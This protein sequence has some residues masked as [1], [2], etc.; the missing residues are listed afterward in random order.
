MSRQRLRYGMIE[1]TTMLCKNCH[2]TGLT[3][4]NENL[5]LSILRNLEIIELEKNTKEINV[6]VPVDV[7][8]YILNYKRRYLKEIEKTLNTNIFIISDLTINNP[9]YLI[10]FR[11]NSYNN[12]EDI[13]LSNVITMDGSNINNTD[14]DLSKSSTQNNNTNNTEI[15]KDTK[16]KNPKRRRRKNSKFR[17]FDV[18]ND[19]KD[20]NHNFEDSNEIQKNKILEDLEKLEIKKVIDIKKKNIDSNNKILNNKNE[21]NNTNVSQNTKNVKHGKYQSKL[22]KKNSQSQDEL[23]HNEQHF[24][25]PANDESEKK[26][27]KTV[28][29]RVI[30]KVEEVLDKKNKIEQKK[31]T[32]G[33]NKK[34][35]TDSDIPKSGWWVRKN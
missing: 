18:K 25:V 12:D 5:S 35:N 28:R 33:S 29:K 24:N 32:N 10:E 6:K 23:T 9:N 4:S 21:K 34:I 11:K 13:S 2:G 17:K 27:K 1:A 8:N 3:R 15:I 16:F 14:E 19:E 22:S 20:I 26:S 31:I 30:K 7:A